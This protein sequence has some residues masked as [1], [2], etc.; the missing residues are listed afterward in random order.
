MAVV[1]RPGQ[2]KRRCFGE[3]KAEDVR[4][5]RKGGRLEWD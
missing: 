4:E 3:E 2:M 1:L 5:L